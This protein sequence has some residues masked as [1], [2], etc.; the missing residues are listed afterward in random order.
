M[1]RF[2]M[3]RSSLSDRIPLSASIT[4]TLKSLPSIVADVP[5]VFFRVIEQ[6]SQK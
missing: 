5:E 1:Y 6:P 3:E 4:Y 2:G